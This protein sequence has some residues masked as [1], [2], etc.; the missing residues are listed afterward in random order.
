MASERPVEIPILNEPLCE[1]LRSKNLF[2]KGERNESVFDGHEGHCWC[3]LT[4]HF[5]GPGRV[6]VDRELCNSSRSCYKAVL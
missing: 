5:Y 4:Q 2:V 1:H 3:N 6:L